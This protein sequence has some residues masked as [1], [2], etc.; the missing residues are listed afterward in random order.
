MPTPHLPRVPRKAMPA[1]L[2]KLWDV[3][4]ERT[5]EATVIEVFANAPELLD[6]YFDDF[7]QGIFYKGRVDVRSKEILR[8]K[9]SK[10]HGCFF[11]NRNNTVDC[12]AAGITQ[13]QIDSIQDP[14]PA[15]FS[16]KDLAIIELAD[17]MMLQNMSG[18]LTGDLYNQLRAHFDDAQIVEL[19]FVSAIL[20]GVAKW[21]FVYDMVTREETCPVSRAPAPEKSS[22]P[23]RA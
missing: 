14:S 10:Q 23:A 18:E 22:A 12:L 4:M 15:I 5:G 3:G 6:W 2:Q 9:L 20:T 13:E 16:D 17:Q 19:G 11:C 1:H 8:L 21:I 7:Y